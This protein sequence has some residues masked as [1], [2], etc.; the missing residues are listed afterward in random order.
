MTL[1]REHAAPMEL[2]SRVGDET[3]NITLLTELRSRR[4]LKGGAIVRSKRRRRAMFIDRTTEKQ[5]SS[6]RS[7]MCRSRFHEQAK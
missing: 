7:V 1:H 6:V 3:I 2:G 5:P 4:K